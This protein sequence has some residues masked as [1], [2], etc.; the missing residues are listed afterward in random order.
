[1]NHDGHIK[2]QMS[3]KPKSN[4]ARLS[5]RSSMH[6]NWHILV[7]F[8]FKINFWWKSLRRLYTSKSGENT[9]KTFYNAKLV[10]LNIKFP[11]AKVKHCATISAIKHVNWHILVYFLFKINFWCKSSCRLYTST[12]ERKK[13]TKRKIGD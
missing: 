10:I 4:D 1:M 6:V 2:D 7:Y 12:S 13:V 11:K 9:F 5:L 3:K 8:L